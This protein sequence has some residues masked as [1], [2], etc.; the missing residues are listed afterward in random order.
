MLY[1]HLVFVAF[2][3]S[4]QQLLLVANIPR[5]LWAGNQRIRMSGKAIVMSVGDCKFIFLSEITVVLCFEEDFDDVKFV[6]FGEKL[7]GIL[8]K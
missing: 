3:Y 1:C 6:S 2:Y 8:L 5:H 7:E 4:E